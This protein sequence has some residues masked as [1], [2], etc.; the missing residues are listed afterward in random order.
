M[1]M[2]DANGQVV[3][4]YE[5]DAW[6]NVLKNDAKGIAAEN[7]FGYAG[8]LY[9]KEIGMYY[10]IAR[11]Y[12]PEHGVFLSID[13]DPGDEDD[14]VTQNGYTYADNNPVMNVDSD[15]HLAWMLFNAGFAAYDGYNAYKKNGWKAA[16]IAVGVGLVG[17]AT[18]KGGKI[19][20]KAAKN[21]YTTTRHWSKGTFKSRS[22][23]L[24]YHH[25]K[26]VTWKEKSYGQ[27]RYTDMARSFYR[28]NKHLRQEV[29][30][31]N[32]KK[33][34]YYTKNGKIITYW[35]NGWKKKKR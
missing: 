28:S 11:Y 2:T 23:S 22:K 34:G 5:Y 12:N 9:D 18:F 25:K 6:G 17:G 32:G 16:A 31:S 20:Y 24:A 15:G 21:W 27:K 13:P 8:Y 26:H 1:A 19:A 7:K 14:P 33:G 3:A 4:N 30:L 10:L 35:N 29:V